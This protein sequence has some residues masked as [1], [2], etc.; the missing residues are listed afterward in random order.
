M[1]NLYP[2]CGEKASKRSAVAG[3]GKAGKEESF[4]EV[5]FTYSMQPSPLMF[6]KNTGL[7]GSP[8]LSKCLQVFRMLT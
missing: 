7:K 6:L 4:T 8:N 3:A 2:A 5:N 1:F